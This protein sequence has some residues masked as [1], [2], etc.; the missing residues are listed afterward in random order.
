MALSGTIPGSVTNKSD[1]FEF[2]ATWSGVQ[3]IANNLTKITVN[4]YFSTT[5]TRNTFD[6]SGTRD[7]SITIDG[8][9]S[10]QKTR[11][12][13]NPWPSNPYLIQTY[14]KDVYHNSDGTKTLTI[15][16]RANGHANQ[17]GP[18]NGLDSSGDCTLSKSITLDTIPRASSVSVGSSSRKPGE[19]QTITIS[20][21][22]SSFTDTVTWSCGSKSGTIATKSSSTS[23]SWTVPMELIKQS[24]NRN[25]TCTITTTTYNGNTVVG[26]KS[27]TFT[28]GYYGA[29]TISKT[30]GNTIGSKISATIS[31]ANSNFTH[32]MWWSF[33]SKTWQ[34][35]GDG[36]TTSASFTPATA[37]FAPLIPS[38]TSGTLTLILRTYY[39]GTQV[40]SD[41]TKTLT[42]NLPSSIV[43][44]IGTPTITVNNPSAA[45]DWG[46]VAGLSTLTVAIPSSGTAAGTGSTIKS[47]SISGGGFSGSSNSLTTGKINGT[48]AI[49]FTCT[50]TDARG[51]TASKTITSAAP[52]SYS[53]PSIT[54]KNAYRATRASNGTITKDSNS[55]GIAV[56]LE[57]TYSSIG[58][59]NTISRSVKA[60]SATNTSFSSGSTVYLAAGAALTNTCTITATISDE[61]GN[62][63]DAS[64]VVYTATRAI[65]INKNKDGVAFGGFN[66]ESE[67]V[68]NY[69]PLKQ[70]GK[71]NF[72]NNE[73][74]ILNSA[75]STILAYNTSG[76][77]GVSTGTTLGSHLNTTTIRGSGTLKHYNGSSVY[78]VLTSGNYNSY[79]LPL[80]GG[81]L[82]GLFVPT[83]GQKVHQASGSIAS[84]FVKVAIF[85]T[86]I[87]GVYL[88]TPFKL[89][90]TQRG[91]KAPCE[92]WI[93][94]TA[95]DTTDTNLENFYTF[96]ADDYNVYLVKS[97]AAT[98]ELYVSKTESY[99]TIGV[100][101]YYADDYVRGRMSVTWTD[102]HVSSL[103]SGYT[104]AKNYLTNTFAPLSHSHSYLSVYG[105]VD[106]DMNAGGYWAA[107]SQKTGIDTQWRHVLSMNWTGSDYNNWVSQ[108]SIP[109]STGASS[110]HYRRSKNGEPIGNRSWITLLDSDNY[111]NYAPPKSQFKV[112][113][114]V[115]KG[116][117]ATSAS[118][119][120]GAYDFIIGTIRPYSSY[121][122]CSFILPAGHMGAEIQVADDGSY[123]KFSTSATSMSRNAGTGTIYYLAGVNIV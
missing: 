92:I 6:T 18:S 110:M 8:S 115:A 105:G 10:S 86:N 77:N 117:A 47:Y 59:K 29:S 116:S 19:S 3:D 25:Q 98:W 37:T 87:G 69:W 1:R 71:I 12:N 5:N 22:S 103:P 27:T 38:A 11:I 104:A 36:L 52:V 2:Y 61:L 118:W 48:S 45:S 95:G 51:R 102:V 7:Q 44:T 73:V 15:S 63:D 39:D 74:E 28:V 91:R 64:F 80:T 17:W 89:T 123:T 33:G 84:G 24:P 62:S 9:T 122:P 58:G 16:A 54:I 113:Q 68:Q 55:T 40:G 75:G 4:T 65:N 120:S 14:T 57:Y 114:I 112:T 21:A 49:T 41:T 42:L 66:T 34:G 43:P 81:T 93:Q 32:Y 56:E 78:D 67:T 101:E 85:K 94:F 109:A 119:T 111:T 76:V 50:V 88:N 97:A 106:Q 100:L 99:D 60:N 79:A 31:R 83:Q 13:C 72:I 108:L 82:S 53:A 107:M 90:I 46:L 70:S 96:G 35:I 30:S 23:H 20:K 26:S 121:S